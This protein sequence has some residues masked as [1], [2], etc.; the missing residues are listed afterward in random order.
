[1]K[2]KRRQSP[3][4]EALL[5]ISALSTLRE[6]LPVSKPKS[7]HGRKRRLHAAN[8]L[9][10]PSGDLLHPAT[11]LSCRTDASVREKNENESAGILLSKLVGNRLVC[12]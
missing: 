7:R 10:Q 11:A 12:P 3:T 2:T 9:P 1:M 5:L 8:H 6:T 4:P